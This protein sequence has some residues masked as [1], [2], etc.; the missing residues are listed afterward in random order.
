MFKGE[1]TIN[2]SAIS[3]TCCIDRVIVFN[4]LIFEILIVMKSTIFTNIDIKK[5][6]SIIYYMKYRNLVTYNATI[7]SRKCCK[8]CWLDLGHP[9]PILQNLKCTCSVFRNG[10]IIK[11]LESIFVD[12]HICIFVFC[13]YM[14]VQ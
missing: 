2:W 4:I 8:R 1:I 10:E 12:R 7:D 6:L 11:I 13:L 5:N 9:A 3:I 14:Y